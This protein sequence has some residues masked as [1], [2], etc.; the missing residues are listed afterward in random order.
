MIKKILKRS[1]KNNEFWIWRRIWRRWIWKRWRQGTA[2]IKK[3]DN[4][5]GGK[6]D[7]V[8]QRPFK[9]QRAVFHRTKS[10]LAAKGLNGVLPFCS[11]PLPPPPSKMGVPGGNV[12]IRRGVLCVCPAFTSRLHTQTNTLT[13]I[14]YSG[15]RQED[16]RCSVSSFCAALSSSM[17][18]S[19]SGRRR[20]TLS[21]QAAT[22]AADENS[23][24]TLV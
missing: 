18:A 17:R 24:C 4:E 10:H 7:A 3:K 16:K 11:F 23:D 5:E 1:L 9:M 19:L 6:E 8:R 20:H 21:Q 12:W 14:H 15:R 2:R 13:L 22:W